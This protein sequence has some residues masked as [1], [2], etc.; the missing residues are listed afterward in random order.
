MGGQYWGDWSIEIYAGRKVGVNIGD[1]GQSKFIRGLGWGLNIGDIGQS[2]FM[3]LVV[4]GVNIWRYWSIEIW[5]GG[6]QYFFNK[7]KKQIKFVVT[8][9]DYSCCA[10]NAVL[11]HGY[12]FWALRLTS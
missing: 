7:S 12:S 9:D 6:S 1:I 2:K 5:S 10:F 8:V 11:S 3:R 4:C